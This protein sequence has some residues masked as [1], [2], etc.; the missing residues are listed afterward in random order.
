MRTVKF[1]AGEIIVSEGDEGNT[2][3]L[4]VDGSV[5][6]SIGKGTHAKRIGALEAG[7]VFGEMSLIEPGLR[8]ATVK[9]VTDTECVAT[10]HD[11]FIASIRDNPDAALE[12]MK[13]LVRRLRHMNELIVSM[14]AGKRS[15]R[16]IFGDWHQSTKPSEPDAS[17]E[18][19][20]RTYEKM[21]VYQRMI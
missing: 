21:M 4:I 17:D 5:E 1:N 3:F 19:E 20:M 7:E 11:E 2:A 16:E 12:F 15:L 8:H 14:D 9:A 6:V 18:A 13:M 10:S